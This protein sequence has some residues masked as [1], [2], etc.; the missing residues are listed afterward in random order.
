MNSRLFD[1][2]PFEFLLPEREEIYRLI[3]L[4][5][6]NGNFLGIDLTSSKLE[7]IASKIK[8]DSKELFYKTRK[9]VFERY[10]MNLK[11][12][13]A[14]FPQTVNAVWEGY[15][16]GMIVLPVHLVNNPKK[17]FVGIDNLCSKDYRERLENI[18][19]KDF[20][21]MYNTQPSKRMDPLL[22]IPIYSFY[23]TKNETL[24]DTIWDLKN[25]RVPF[26]KID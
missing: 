17:N 1:D 10:N 2:S 18:L 8:N 25:P 11:D 26:L 4:R 13:S 24:R 21:Q 14:I 22:E 6:L 5:V 3:S 12:Y 23:D 7:G 19:G 9:E 15:K 20:P 16:N